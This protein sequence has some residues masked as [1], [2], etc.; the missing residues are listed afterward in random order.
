MQKGKGGCK[1]HKKG[2]GGLELKNLGG[3]LVSGMVGVG[4]KNNL[5]L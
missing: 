1:I 2:G 5:L 4:G 3:K